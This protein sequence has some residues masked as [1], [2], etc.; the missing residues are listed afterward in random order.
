MTDTAHLT[1]T[2][3]PNDWY[4]IT[5]NGN[6]SKDY[7]FDI[8]IEL[9]PPPGI[10]PE[11]EFISSH[12][13]LLAGN[14]TQ[15]GEE[16]SITKEQL[17][18]M[19]ANFNQNVLGTDP[20]V[21][22][23]HD[24]EKKAAGWIKHLELFEQDNQ[25]GLLATIRWTKSGEKALSDK[26]FRYFSA[27]FTFDFFDGSTGKSFGPVLRGG[28]LTNIPFLRHLPA[29]VELHNKQTKGVNQMA[30]TMNLSDH[31]AQV[32]VLTESIEDLKKSNKE[33][34]Q[35]ADKVKT[36]ESVVKDLTDK[37][38]ELVSDMSKQKREVKFAGLLKK[39][40]AVE[41]QREAY[42]AGEMDKFL[43]LAQPVNLD[44]HGNA[45]EGDGPTLKFANQD[46]ENQF[47]RHL[48]KTMTKEQY[49]SAS[50]GGQP[51]SKQATN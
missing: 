7:H 11:G 35:T 46:E 24:N 18:D 41:A 27:S 5:M 45:G 8:G 23:S 28:A 6:P 12:P 14:F 16:F 50:R 3:M 51:F 25:V 47:N 42:M 4:H 13:I 29:I 15:N 2:S 31:N 44:E 10:K 32:K 30:D 38:V 19:V 37:N 17:Q 49:L 48:S 26:E 20:P 9:I 21:D 43:E 34:S 36:L 40:S 39:G 1:A 33:L 22:F